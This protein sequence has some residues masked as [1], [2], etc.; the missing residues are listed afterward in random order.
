V[1]TAQSL[2][3]LSVGM[4]QAVAFSLVAL[5]A[6]HVWLRMVFVPAGLW[7]GTVA[8]LW[9]LIPESSLFLRIALIVLGAITVTAWILLPLLGKNRG[10]VER[11]NRRYPSVRFACPRC[12]TRVDWMQG[13]AACTDCGLFMHLHWPADEAQAK[14]A[15][16]A[17]RVPR[18][19]VR[20]V[21]FACPACEQVAPWPRGDNTCASCGLK[22]SIFWNVHAKKPAPAK[23]S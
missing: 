1:R 18:A 22:L 4:A 8:A 13:V 10:F 14:N 2:A 3:A 20:P 16:D 11:N 5:P 21:E 9:F 15:E 6:R 17:V 7:T 19:A 23:K 12:G